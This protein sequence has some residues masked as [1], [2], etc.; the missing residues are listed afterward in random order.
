[1]KTCS[2]P[3][4]NKII[5]QVNIISHKSTSLSDN[6]HNC[7][8]S[9]LFSNYGDMSDYYADFSE[10]YVDLSDNDFDLSDIKLTSR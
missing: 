4:N 3:V 9:R 2:C 8:K 6:R 7:L 10:N 5:W 1:M